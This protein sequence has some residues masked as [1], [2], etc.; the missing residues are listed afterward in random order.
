[1]QMQMQT[2]IR[3]GLG[4][5]G[6][7]KKYT[8]FT[9]SMSKSS[10]LD[11]LAQLLSEGK[12]QPVVKKVWSMYDVIDAHELLESRHCVGKSII[13]VRK[14]PPQADDDSDAEPA[15]ARV[16]TEESKKTL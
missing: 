8:I 15:P 7:S 4:Y 1:M 12:L 10:D 5:L 13:Q 9:P 2:G 14:G 6:A 11:T 16:E 3:K